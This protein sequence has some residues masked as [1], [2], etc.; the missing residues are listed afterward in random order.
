M[1]NLPKVTLAESV[2]KPSLEIVAQE[3]HGGT[4]AAAKVQKLA[5]FNYSMQRRSSV[6]AASLQEIVLAK[7]C[8]VPCFCFDRVKRLILTAKLS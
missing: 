2:V 7:L 8:S 6:I 3:I 4:M 5:L 1:R